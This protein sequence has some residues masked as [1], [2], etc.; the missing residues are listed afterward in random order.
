MSARFA[1]RRHAGRELTSLLLGYAD[2]ADVTVLALPRGGVPVA[3]EIAQSLDAPLDVFVVRKLGMPGH[4]EYAMGAIASGGVR[5]LDAGIVRSNLVTEQALAYVIAREEQELERREQLF[6]G[7]RPPASVAGRT[8][9]IVDDGLATG[10]TMRVAVAALR[11]RSAAR[12]LV[13]VPVSSREA[14]DAVRAGADEVFCLLIPEAFIAVGAW[15]DNFA[16]T[17][18]DEVRLLLG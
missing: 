17:T 8:V 18:D 7:D 14:Y 15:Y 13:A 2:R 10:A 5:V 12:L 1:D 4:D 9:I 3:Y 16:Q 11:Q 6:R